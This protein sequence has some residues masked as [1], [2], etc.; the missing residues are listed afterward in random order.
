MYRRGQDALDGPCLAWRQGSLYQQRQR[1]GRAGR[2]DSNQYIAEAGA[3]ATFTER[4]DITLPGSL[5]STKVPGIPTTT[6]P[7][8]IT[9]GLNPLEIP[10]IIA[11]VGLHIPLVKKKYQTHP[12]DPA[13]ITTTSVFAPQDLLACTAVSRKWR[14]ILLP[15][16]WRTYD[17]ALMRYVP[18]HVLQENSIYFRSF[19]DQFGHYHPGPFLTGNLRRLVISYQHSWAV[20]FMITNVTLSYLTWTGCGH[21][22]Q[23]D[24]YTALLGLSHLR[25]LCLSNWDLSGRQ[26]PLILCASPNLVRLSLSSISGVHDLEGMLIMLALEEIS[27]GF[28]ASDSGCLLELVQYSPQLRRISFLGTWIQ[29]QRRDLILLSAQ[30]RVYCPEMTSIWFSASYCFGTDSFATLEDFEYAALVQGAQSLHYFAAEIACLGMMLTDALISQFHALAAVDLCIRRRIQYQHPHDGGGGGIGG[31]GMGSVNNSD[32]ASG[33]TSAASGE[34]SNE[35]CSALL[36]DIVNSSRILST[37]SQ[38]RVFRLSTAENAIDM[39]AALQLF[40]VPWACLGLEVLSL[41]HISL[42]DRSKQQESRDLGGDYGRQIQ[43]SRTCVHDY[44]ASTTSTTSTTTFNTTTA[45]TDAEIAAAAAA[46]TFICSNTLVPKS[47]NM[48][49]ASAWSTALTPPTGL[50]DELWMFGSEFRRKLLPQIGL[51]TMLRE[52]RLNKVQYVRI[53]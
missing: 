3:P 21:A 43:S 10:E 34:S 40:S 1:A 42:P 38:L 4:Q 32:L 45:I 14:W 44:A 51:L 25:D 20:P 5:E 49:P 16:L 28:V 8:F 24:E 23:D 52:I 53:V 12:F 39:E 11:M 50:D 36:V 31:L 35:N 6:M 17:G 7:D 18:L 13:I 27:L 9:P 33:N 26:L 29:E 37:C 30:I 46:T 15:A 19:R 2:S 47:S 41:G 22:L 48:V